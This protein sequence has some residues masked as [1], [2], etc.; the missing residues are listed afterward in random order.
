MTV[1]VDSCAPWLEGRAHSVHSQFG[2]DGLIATVFNRIGERNRW[3]FEV[4]AS[5]G[6]TFSNTKAL[7]DAG[8]SA[9]L[10]EANAGEFAKL[11]EHVSDTV[12]CVH[13]E[14]DAHNLEDLLS[15]NGCPRDVDFGSID[16]DGQDYWIWSGLSRFQPR[17]ILIEFSPYVANPLFIPEYGADGQGGKCQAGLA[18]MRKLGKELG[19]VAVAQTY[20]NLLFVLESEL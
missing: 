3:C 16:I 10:I 7:R 14:I 12:H 20:C 13:A 19:Y 15:F 4:G 9:V 2:E 8:W 17:V 1:R 11:E 6:V 18:A 5:D